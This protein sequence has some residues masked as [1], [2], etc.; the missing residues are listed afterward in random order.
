MDLSGNDRIGLTIA[1]V[2]GSD[3]AII[4]VPGTP[5]CMAHSS[6]RSFL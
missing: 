3:L 1:A 5:V 4:D 6:H 2:A